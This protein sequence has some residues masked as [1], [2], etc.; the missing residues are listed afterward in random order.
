MSKA[1][2]SSRDYDESKIDGT[3][4]AIIPNEGLLSLCVL[5]LGNF[6]ALKYLIP[7]LYILVH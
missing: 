7:D 3:S 4:Q 5:S 2:G 1:S 6:D